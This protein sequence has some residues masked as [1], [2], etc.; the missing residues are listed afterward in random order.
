MA[1]FAVI[2]LGVFGRTA[3][4]ELSRL[5]NQVIGIDRDAQYVNAIKDHLDYAVI[6]DATEEQT[7]AELNLSS[8]NGVLVAIGDDLE[9]SLLCVLALQ[10]A[11]VTNLWV[12]AKSDAH[13]TILSRMN[14]TRIIH[15]EQEMGIRIAQSLNY[16]H[17]Q[18][19]LSLGENQYIIKLIVPHGFAPRPLRELMQAHGKLTVHA[20][21]RHEQLQ[22]V[23][24]FWTV[25]PQDRLI[26]AGHLDQL[27]AFLAQLPQPT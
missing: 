16:P 2:G 9:A 14:V 4:L 12:K 3:A 1:Q 26:V 20:I 11:G 19:Y 7:I 17:V 25:E 13:H 5:G 18:Q 23:N 15:P 8:C 21:K 10:K 22:P 27:K 24:P 6:A